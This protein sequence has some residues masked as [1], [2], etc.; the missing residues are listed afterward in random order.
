MA[1]MILVFSMAMSAYN[2]FEL[3]SIETYA[4]QFIGHNKS[5]LGSVD[6]FLHTLAIAWTINSSSL[7]MIMYHSDIMANFVC[8]GL[9]LTKKISFFF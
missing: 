8:N 2:S 5:F 1:P 3:I 7:F 4:L 9:K 6:Y